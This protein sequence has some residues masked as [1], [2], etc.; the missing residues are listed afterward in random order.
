MKSALDVLGVI[1]GVGFL[2]GGAIFLYLWYRDRKHPDQKKLGYG[3]V[4]VGAILILAR[5]LGLSI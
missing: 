4:A 5:L 3:F 1:A 2:A